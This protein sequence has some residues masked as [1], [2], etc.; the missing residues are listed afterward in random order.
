M[1]KS[2]GQ[3]TTSWVVGLNFDVWTHGCPLWTGLRRN[4]N[5]IKP[6]SFWTTP[7]TLQAERLASSQT[8]GTRPMS[9][10][11]LTASLTANGTVTAQLLKKRQ[12]RKRQ[13]QNANW[14]WLPSPG[15]SEAD[16]QGA[17]IPRRWVRCQKSWWPCYGRN[18]GP[19][20]SRGGQTQVKP[21]RKTHVKQTKGAST[22]E[23]LGDG[24]SRGK[25]S[26]QR[27]SEWHPGVS[28][29]G[30]RDKA[31]IRQP[32]IGDEEQVCGLTAGRDA[33]GV[34]QESLDPNR[35]VV[36]ILDLVCFF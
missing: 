35:P 8:R 11:L 12:R 13:K 14:W 7:G 23:K 5:V 21:R 3:M 18:R 20:G 30:R 31:T 6:M 10:T 15:H 32:S 34:S 28:Q 33:G 16:L 25:W 1:V 22:G 27:K 29:A 9:K 24:P 26:N 17:Q 36:M 19:R 2:T 4:P